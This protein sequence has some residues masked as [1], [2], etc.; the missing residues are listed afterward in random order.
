MSNST[1]F[2]RGLAASFGSLI[3]GGLFWLVKMYDI[4]IGFFAVSG[5]GF[6]GCFLLIIELGHRGETR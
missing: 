2:L 4:S 1:A 6:L 3:F 5:F